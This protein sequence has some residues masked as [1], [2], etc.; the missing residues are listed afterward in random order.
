VG[1]ENRGLEYMFVM[2]NAARFAVGIEGVGLSERA[3]QRAL[4]YA[5]ERTQGTEL[6]SKAKEKVAIVRH[7]DVKRMLL[8]MKSRTEAMRALACVVAAAGDTARLHP[9]AA[10]RS[11]AQAFVDLMIPVVK[12]WSTESAVEIASPGVQVHGGMGY[13]E[14]TG[15]A[16]H[17][18]D[19]RITPIYE[20]TTGIQAL[21]L[22]GRKVARDKGQAIG[23]VIARMR[24]VEGELER[25]GGEDLAAIAPRL[26]DGVA[27]LEHAV[28][29]VVS[30]FG[31]DVRRVAAGAVPFL[32]LLGTVA[33][34]WQMGRAALAARRGLAAPAEAAFCR[35]KIATARFY[36]DHVLVRAPGLSRTVVTGADAVLAI[37]DEQL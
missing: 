31:A 25:A 7:P 19:A 1:E 23:A 9:D 14:E 32:E 34:G 29:F 6:G 11:A 3:Y 30:T 26:R 5:R 17:L 4:D 35:A 13:V 37:E 8:L 10:R 33:G 15:A 36:A 22:V 16:Q 20:G 27:A 24:E 2:M 21:D 28:Q 12:G 18:R